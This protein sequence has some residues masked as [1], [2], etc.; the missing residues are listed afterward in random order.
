MITINWSGRLGNRMMQFAGAW[1]LSK[2][3]CIELFKKEPDYSSMLHT[4]GNFK[5]YFD[6]LPVPSTVMPFWEIESNSVIEINDQWVKDNYRNLSN[7]PPA[8]YNITEQ[9]QVPEFLNYYFNEI[10]SIYIPK[11]PLQEK[12]GVLVHCRLGDISLEMSAP[13]NYYKKALANIKSRGGYIVTDPMSK[14]HE[15]I[16][17]LS[18]EFN[19]KLFIASPVE[20]LNFS[21]GFKEIVVGTGTFG[22]WLG[23]LNPDSK[24]FYYKIPRVHAWH[25]NIFQVNDWV[26]I[27]A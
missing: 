24:T 26:G 5:E 21:R 6:I 27:E 23:A 7:T 2:Y 8:R 1:I 17:Q 16:Q 25:P 20:T 11:I 9:M 12:E 15:L 14:D 22:W 19:L 10:K 4:Y 18:N 3:S 13:L